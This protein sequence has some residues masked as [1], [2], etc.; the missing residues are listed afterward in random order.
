MFWGLLDPAPDT[1]ARGTD[2]DWTF[3]YSSLTMPYPLWYFIL[4]NSKF[5]TSMPRKF[6]L[7]AEGGGEGLKRGPILLCQ[8]SLAVLPIRIRD[9]VSGAFLTPESGIRE[10]KKSG[11]GSG[12]Q[13]RNELPRSYFRELRNHFLG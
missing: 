5:V 6:S 2:P 10:G 3:M 4:L 8:Y 7:A 11:S 9:P 1:L 12:I 13:I